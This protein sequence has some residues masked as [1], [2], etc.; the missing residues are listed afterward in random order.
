MKVV[1]NTCYGGFNLSNE[2]FEEYLKIKDIKF[3]TD[4]G[5]FGSK[6]YYTVPVEEYVAN[7]Q[8]C[9]EKL[10]FTETDGLYL[11]PYDIERNDPILVSIV[12]RLKEKADGTYARLKIV[13]VPDDVQ[14]VIEEYDGS[15]WVAES[16]RTW[17]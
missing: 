10:D 6:N 11:S 4:E 8:K 12:E 2:A 1:I 13:E 5:L 3:Y 7:N 14:W 17:S 16:H 15:E 9:S